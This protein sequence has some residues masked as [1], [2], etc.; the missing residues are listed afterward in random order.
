MSF[1]SIV[2]NIA[3]GIFNHLEAKLGVVQED[4]EKLQHLSNQELADIAKHENDIHK[5]RAACY[6]LKQRGF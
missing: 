6:I 2:G 4:A 1:W 5:K 3:S